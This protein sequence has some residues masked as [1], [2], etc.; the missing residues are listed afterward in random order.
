MKQDVGTK[1]SQETH[2]GRHGQGNLDKTIQRTVVCICM[3]STEIELYGHTAVSSCW[4]LDSVR[5]SGADYHLKQC[6][7][8]QTLLLYPG[9]LKG[10]PTGYSILQKGR[11]WVTGGEE[12]R[13]ASKPALDELVNH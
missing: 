12:S 8:N 13:P 4:S 7:N 3:L 1:T 11:G 6:S 9:T 2:S 10:N 5:G